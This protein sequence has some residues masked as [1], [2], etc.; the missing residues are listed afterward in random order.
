[1]QLLVSCLSLSTALRPDGGPRLICGGLVICGAW[2]FLVLFGR[3]HVI[4][5]ARKVQTESTRQYITRYFRG[6][7]D[8]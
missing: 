6:D 8:C 4:T 1:M 3:Q 5:K 2:P 7:V